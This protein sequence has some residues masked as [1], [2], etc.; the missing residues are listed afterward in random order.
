MRI[1]D[2]LLP[3]R[4]GTDYRWLLGASWTANLGDGIA[5]AAGPLLVASLTRDPL[6]VGLSTFLLFAP[7]MLIGLYAGV[8]V[9]RS[10]R[11]TVALVTDALRALLLVAVV[12]LIVTDTLTVGV[13]LTMV[14]LI[15]VTETFADGSFSAM[16]PQ[17]VGPRDLGV[18]NA[19]QMAGFVVANRLA[20]PPLGAALFTVGTVW[21]Y[22]AQV[23]LALLA[24]VLMSR[25][26]LRRGRVDRDRTR[27]A[28]ARE[29][30]EGLRWLRGHAALRT[31]T[32]TI[33]AFNV[34]FGATLAVLV[35]YAL[36]VLEMGEVGYGLLTTASA[37]GGLIGMVAYDRLEGAL[38][39]GVLMRIGLA[40]ETVFHFVF[41][42]N[43]L[44][45]VALA[46]MVV[47]G[48]HEFVW[49]T[50]MTTIR[51][52][53]VPEALQGRVGSAYRFAGTAGLAAGAGLGSVLAGALG[54]VAPFWFGFVGSVLLLVWLWRPLMQ[55]AHADEVSEVGGVTAAD[56]PR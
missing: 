10:D 53:A 47:F 49:G 2:R 46:M 38:P 11:R 29:V 45:V 42:L 12:A 5:L 7:P 24:V 36:E 17:L 27:G 16:L 28:A 6:L 35:L 34:T 15:G 51:M 21:P 56:A 39:L 43:R 9:D 4:L 54:V 40:V 33:F 19:R 41:A 18:A 48:V 3:S 25:I 13:L 50:I 8:V 22:A 32:I 44:P 23:V 55:V 30:R 1:L 31:L 52:R 20:G 14:F 26:T 37:V